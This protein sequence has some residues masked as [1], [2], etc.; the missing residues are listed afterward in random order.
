MSRDDRR[1]KLT[2]NCPYCNAP[3]EMDKLHTRFYRCKT[4]ANRDTGQYYRRCK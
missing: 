3:Q 1:P 2:K 4:T